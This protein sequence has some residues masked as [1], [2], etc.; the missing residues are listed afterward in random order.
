MKS[1]RILYYLKCKIVMRRQVVK[2]FLAE[3]DHSDQSLKKFL[4]ESDYSDQSLKKFPAESDYSDQ[5]CRL[6]PQICKISVSLS[7]SSRAYMMN[8][9]NGAMCVAIPLIYCSFVILA[10]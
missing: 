4:A 9:V 7:V 5:I 8:I 2:T 3:S 1:F 10:I 6:K